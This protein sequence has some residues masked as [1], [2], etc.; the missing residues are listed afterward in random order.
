MDK[1]TDT[2]ERFFATSALWKLLWTFYELFYPA[3]SV[4]YFILTDKFTD[5]F[6]YRLCRIDRLYDYFLS[7]LPSV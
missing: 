2:G 3:Y 1:Q 4:E 5:M 7:L 6:Y